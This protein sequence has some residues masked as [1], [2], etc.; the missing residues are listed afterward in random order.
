MAGREQRPTPAER[1]RQQQALELRLRGHSY[2]EIAEQLGYRGKG[3]AWKAVAAVLDRAESETAGEY[4]IVQDARYSTLFRAW[5]PAALDG[6]EKAAAVVLRTL[7]AVS[8]LHGLNRDT[9]TDT[10][11]H[12]SPNEFQAALAEYVALSTTP[13]ALE[14]AGLTDTHGTDQEN[15]T[16]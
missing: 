5:W 1:H 11:G 4:R 9:G 12:M 15:N 16:P 13:A 7:E 2:D 14:A 3:S 8:R 10:N 6:D